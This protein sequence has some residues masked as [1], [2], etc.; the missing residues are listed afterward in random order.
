MTGDISTAQIPQDQTPAGQGDVRLAS[1]LAAATAL[2]YAVI[3]F[4]HFEGD[5]FDGVAQSYEWLAA[6]LVPAGSAVSA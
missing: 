4:D 2:E 1:A 3:E 6:Q 5:V